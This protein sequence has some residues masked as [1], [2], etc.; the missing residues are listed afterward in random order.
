VVVA[1]TVAL[2][3]AQLERL[4][5]L[6]ADRLAKRLAGALPPPERPLTVAEVAEVLGMSRA[7]VYDH[8]DELGAIRRGAGRRPR[9]RF[10]P[11]IVAAHAR[12]EATAEREAEPAPSTPTP[13]RRGA[14]G[15]AGLLPIRGRP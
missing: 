3:D 5:D 2:D 4:A 11:A 15:R 13:G 1:M 14:G 7:Y 9:L 6:V 8:A 12:R 10:D